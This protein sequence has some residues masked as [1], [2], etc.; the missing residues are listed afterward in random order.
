MPEI[1]R[2]PGSYAK[3]GIPSVVYT[4]VEQKMFDP[5]PEE[6]IKDTLGTHIVDVLET[7]EA[8]DLLS[9]MLL[10]SSALMALI[11]TL[12]KRKKDTTMEQNKY[13][14]ALAT[15]DVIN[16]VETY[17]GGDESPP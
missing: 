12:L 4:V 17:N 15:Q 2:N 10:T 7:D 6:A 14:W 16:T 13:S 3:R 5:L 8:L 11:A 9:K 1:L